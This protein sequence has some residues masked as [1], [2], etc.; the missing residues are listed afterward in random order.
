MHVWLSQT[1]TWL[2]T[3]VNA[4]PSS[5]DSHIVSDKTAHLDQFPI[6]NLTSADQDSYLWKSLG[7]KSWQVAWRRGRYLLQ[8]Q[9]KLVEAEVLHSHFGDRGWQNMGFAERSGL[10]HVVTF[11]GY[12]ASRLP[13]DQ[14]VW[15]DR[16]AAL[17]ESGDR[18]LCEGPHLAM[19]LCELGCP[20]KKIQVHH[21]GIPVDSIMYKERYRADNEPLRVLIAGTFVEKKGIPIAIRALGKVKN[22]VDLEI[23]IIGDS[24]GQDRSEREKRD[25]IEAIA[26]SGLSKQVKLLGYQAHREFI[27]QAYEHH[28]F[29]SPSVHADDG[30]S[31]GGAPVSLIEM[32]ATGIPIIS[33]RHC[34]IPNIIVDGESGLLAKERDVEELSDKLYWL[35][36][37][38]KEWTSLTK[39][40]RRRIE[41][42]FDSVEQGKR[43]ERIYRELVGRRKTGLSTWQ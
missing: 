14:P 3:Q 28:L 32:A 26:R 25:I 35:I 41:Q 15:R 6:D 22:D 42:E 21:L 17:F 23:T 9:A 11:Y 34:D 31:E 18:F 16:F 13:V 40:A 38:P 1:M 36:S 12:D 27:R 2:F 19:T 39:C 37:N 20:E 10:K 7:Q 5:I 30:D 8:R 33:S 29:L 43:L 24:N 4:L